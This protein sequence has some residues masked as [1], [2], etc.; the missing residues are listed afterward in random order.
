MNYICIALLLAYCKSIELMTHYSKG[1]KIE[2]PTFKHM[3]ATEIRTKQK[4]NKF[5]N[6]LTFDK[7]PK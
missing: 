2:N 3:H 5:Q 4:I 7:V 6:S 1:K